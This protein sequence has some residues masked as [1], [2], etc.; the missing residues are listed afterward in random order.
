MLILYGYCTFRQTESQKSS[1]TKRSNLKFYYNLQLNKR[2]KSSQIKTKI[3][4][5]TKD[6][7]IDRSSWIENIE[8]HIESSCKKNV[9]SKQPPTQESI[10]KKPKK[11]KTRLKLEPVEALSV[12]QESVTSNT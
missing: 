4:D 6:V 12:I 8:Q 10:K 11:L 5:K 9:I 3:I 7:S 1:K 2:F